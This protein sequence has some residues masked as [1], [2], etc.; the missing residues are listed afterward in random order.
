MGTTGAENYTSKAGK[1]DLSGAA[2]VTSQEDLDALSNYWNSGMFE[3]VDGAPALTV[4]GEPGS[5]QLTGIPLDQN[6]NKIS[7]APVS[8][9]SHPIMMNGDRLF[10]PP[11]TPPPSTD[12]VVRDLVLGG[13]ME[14]L[15]KGIDPET[16]Q[17]S[18]YGELGETAFDQND[19]LLSYR[20]QW[21][22]DNPEKS[23]SI[24]TDPTEWTDELWKIVDPGMTREALLERFRKTAQ[25][26]R[27]S[28]GIESDSRL[29]SATAVGR[30]G[31]PGF[32]K[33]VPMLT[34][35]TTA[36]GESIDGDLLRIKI[37]GEGQTTDGEN[38]ET[39]YDYELYYKDENGA[40]RT[41]K[42]PIGDP[43]HSTASNFF[44]NLSISDKATIM[45][46]AGI[47]PDAEKKI[48]S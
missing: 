37:I 7:D 12:E 19:L 11:T 28:A 36:A 41:V 29:S 22:R 25:E 15:F 35:V 2:Y 33:P 38:P 17:L 21:L 13:K 30:D 4:S 9:G 44:N 43:A 27:D 1:E 48:Q 5:L 39:V 26:A 46:Q 6:G 8:I 42:V 31:K 16:A 3:S 14:G 45:R 40:L 18:L 20:K 34:G 32:E 23:D 24:P 10:D 47:D